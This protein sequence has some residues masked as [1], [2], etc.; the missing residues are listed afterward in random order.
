M[1][2]RYIYHEA[3]EAEI[4]TDDVDMGCELKVIKDDKRDILPKNLLELQ[5]YFEDPLPVEAFKQTEFLE[6]VAN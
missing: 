6:L 3:Y 4:E 2:E 5:E 1:M